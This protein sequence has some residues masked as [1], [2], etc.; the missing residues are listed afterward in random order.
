MKRIDQCPQELFDEL[1]ALDISDLRMV[2]SDCRLP[3]LEFICMSRLLPC[4]F[5]LP[6][7]QCRRA[8]VKEEIGMGK[9]KE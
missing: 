6:C 3:L 7:E 1:L 8:E 4:D 2:P 9:R 5:K